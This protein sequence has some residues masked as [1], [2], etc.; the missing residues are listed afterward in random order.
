MYKYFQISDMNFTFIKLTKE[1]EYKEDEED[2]DEEE[3]DEGECG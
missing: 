1:E 2:N 3:G